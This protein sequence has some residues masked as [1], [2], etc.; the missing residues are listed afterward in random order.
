M[1]SNKFLLQIA[2]LKTKRAKQHT[3]KTNEKLRVAQLYT[4]T[5][6]ALFFFIRSTWP[7]GKNGMKWKQIASSVKKT[8]SRKDEPVPK[9]NYLYW[10]FCKSEFPLQ[11]L[12]S[13]SYLLHARKGQSSNEKK[14]QRRKEMRP[15]SHRFTSLCFVCVCVLS[16]SAVI[17]FRLKFYGNV[18]K[19]NR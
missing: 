11:L 18:V 7:N 5:H 14:I 4:H 12:P 6:I 15:K 16:I 1:G 19:Y 9:K 2:L 10:W 3:N 13:S 8:S 17:Q